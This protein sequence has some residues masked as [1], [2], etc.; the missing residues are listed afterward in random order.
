MQPG[1]PHTNLESL[2]AGIYLMIQLLKSKRAEQL[3]LL[4]SL[5]SSTTPRMFLRTVKLELYNNC[6]VNMALCLYDWKSADYDEITHNI[7]NSDQYSSRNKNLTEEIRIKL[8]TASK[9]CY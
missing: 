6:Q 8:R 5:T 9:S 4:I 1:R 2:N 3:P 7:A